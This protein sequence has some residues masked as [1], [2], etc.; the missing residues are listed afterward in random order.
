MEEA[1]TGKPPRRH[2]VAEP[3]AEAIRTGQLDV[4]DLLS[5]ADAREAEAEE[6]D[7]THPTGRPA[8]ATCAARRV[9]SQ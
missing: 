3:L 2:E 5:L 7:D 6:E 8:R 4:A 1:A 9:S